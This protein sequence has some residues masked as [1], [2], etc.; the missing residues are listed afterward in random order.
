MFTRRA[1]LTAGLFT[2]ALVLTVS[3]QD[4]KDPLDVDK[5]PRKVM[6]TLKTRFPRAE[7]HKW[8]KEKEG[9]VVIYDI[10]FTQ[11]KQKYEADIKEDG[12]IHNWEMEIPA[13]DVPEAV[14]AAVDKKYPKA[15]WKEIMQI[16]EVKNGKEVLEGFEIVLETADKKEVEVT[17]APD[18]K[19]LEDSTAEKKEE[20]KEEK[21][22]K[23]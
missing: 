21:K 20:K 2:L 12:T 9:D 11:R 17:V 22:D 8:T 13:K 10:E 7:I 15:A 18:G 3:A 6:Y 4:K 16:T 1:W 23:R 14:K 19:I 5:I